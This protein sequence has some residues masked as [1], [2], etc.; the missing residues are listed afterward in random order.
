M[1]EHSKTELEKL[2]VEAMEE[3]FIRSPEGKPFAQ[4]YDQ[5]YRQKAALKKMYDEFWHRAEQPFM[6]YLRN[7]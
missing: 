5:L 1:H 4:E 6:S 2:A 7:L 3:H